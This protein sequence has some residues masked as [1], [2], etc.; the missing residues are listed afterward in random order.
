MT[1]DRRTNGVRQHV[2][3]D[4]KTPNICNWNS[5]LN[6]GHSL[7]EHDKPTCLP[8][9]QRDIL[10][11]TLTTSVLSLESGIKQQVLTIQYVIGANINLT[12]NWSK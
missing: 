7:F 2:C 11:V 6:Y 12:I 9:D 4:Y 5:V 8:Y 10:D 3:T 1:V